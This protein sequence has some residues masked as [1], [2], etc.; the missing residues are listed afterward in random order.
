MN[1]HGI[2]QRKSGGETVYDFYWLGELVNEV[3]F[4]EYLAAMTKSA[5]KDLN[6][7]TVGM[8]LKAAL[9]EGEKT[10]AQLDELEKIAKLPLCEACRKL[11]GESL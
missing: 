9:N 10:V 8:E 2:H 4:N 5:E 6:W 3:D 1:K 7:M 11:I